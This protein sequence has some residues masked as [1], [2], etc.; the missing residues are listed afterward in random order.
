MIEWL[1]MLRQESL[2]LWIVVVGIPLGVLLGVGS[3]LAASRRFKIFSYLMAL[4]A[5]VV[6][7]CAVVWTMVTA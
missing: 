4:V 7:L 6:A 5:T 1:N 3:F 2:L